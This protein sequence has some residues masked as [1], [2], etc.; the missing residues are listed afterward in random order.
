MTRIIKN[1]RQNFKN[2]LK[3]LGYNNISV[4]GIQIKAEKNNITFLYCYNYDLYE[5]K[6]LKKF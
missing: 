1:L 3:R 6:L 4:D 2:Y 5:F